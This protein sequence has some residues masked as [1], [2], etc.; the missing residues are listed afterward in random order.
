MI[1]ITKEQENII[2]CYDNMIINSNPGAGKTS[3]SLL[4]CKKHNNKKILILTYNSMLK[5]EV[6]NKIKENKMNN[7]DVH[8]YHSLITTF[9]DNSGFDDEHISKIINNDK[10]INIVISKYDIIII[11]E[12]QDMISLYL[13]VIKKFIKDTKSEN[14]IIILLGDPKQCIYGFKNASS[15][16]LTLGK[17]IWNKNFV[18]KTLNISFRLTNQISWFVNN[19][20]NTNANIKSIKDGPKVDY[21]ITNSF[22]AYKKIG[23][24]IKKMINEEKY[25]PNDFFILVPSIRSNNSPYKKLENY[26]T[27]F[28][29]PCMTP[30]SDE[31]KLDETVINNK[32]LIIS[33]HQSKGREAKVVIIYGFDNTYFSYYGKNLNQ[34]KCPNP[35]FVAITRAKEKLILIQEEKN[36]QLTFLNLE[37]E[38]IKKYVNIIKSN[39]KLEIKPKL[40]IEDTSF[41]KKN[42]SELVKFLSSSTLNNLIT[43]TN[44]I[45]ETITTQIN[46]VDIKLKIETSH[47]NYEDI[48]DINGLAI[49]CIYEKKILGNDNLSTIEFYV[50]KHIIK[51]LDIKKYAGEIKIP[52]KT[53][54]DYLKVSNIYSALQNNLHSKIASIK[55]YN[56]INDN[57]I[58]L[59]LENLKFIN[60][61]NLLFEYDI[62]NND[63][64]TE[65]C[66]IY[67]HPIFGN[68]H[69]FGRIDAFDTD[70][71]YEF[72]CVSF[73]TIEHKLQLIIYYWLW[74]NSNLINIYGI[75]NAIIINIRTGETLKLINNIY[76]INQIFDLIINDKMTCIEELSDNEFINNNK[77]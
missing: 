37:N 57:E 45:F 61:N 42:V 55:N 63:L 14:A 22:N 13:K 16:F 43:L 46:I 41:V 75:K 70:N 1:K 67:N 60:N 17:E 33:Y 72:K 76:T 19:C 56:W 44:S 30:I 50:I 29:I 58:S 4:I 12:T 39:K 15:Q 62:T 71:I 34:N 18:Y 25:K 69:I 10:K 54:S 11:D 28:N 77:F 65:N 68:I 8:S 47:N 26:L 51:D 32:I 7:C 2:N 24:Q 35:L 73:L 59:L 5:M 21:Y 49:P 64:D 53:T 36:P 23:L 40:I 52:C 3:T 27:K 66:F 48:S 6:R 31:S 20:V 38:N 9:Y 74:I